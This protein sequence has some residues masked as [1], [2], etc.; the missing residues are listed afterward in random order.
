MPGTRLEA[1]LHAVSD[2]ARLEQL[3]AD[4][5]IRDGYTVDPTGTRGPD[6]GRD[7]LL[8]RNG[9]Q[10]ILHCS[11][12]EQ[13]EEKLHEDAESA[14]DR[15]ED[16]T[17]FIFATTQNPAGTRRDRLEAEISD[18]YGWHVTILD[19]ERLR[20]RLSGNPDNHDLVRDHLNIDPSHA[21]QDPAVDA[22]TFYND[23]IDRLQERDG[24][25][26]TIATERTLSDQDDLPILAVHIIPAE[27]FGGDHDRLGADLPDPPGFGQRGHTQRYGDFVLTGDSRALD[28]D[29]PFTHY[30]CFHE[31]GWAEAV[32]VNIVP[33]TDALE[34]LPNI[35]RYLVDFL[36][37]A[38]D[39]YQG[40]GINPPFHTYLSLLNAAA[41][42]TYVPDRVW[43]PDC[44]REIGSDVFRFGEVVIDRLDEDVPGLLRK[45]I[46]RLW[47]RTGWT[48]SLNY[49]E[50]EENGETFY[51]WNPR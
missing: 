18:E 30:S 50:V 24:Y 39:W 38:L 34:L 19:L 31:D 8:A 46:Y 33:K 48:T 6:G 37:D 35:D 15:P 14:V 13:W 27:A 40:V 4:L 36:E 47:S 5:L 12:S 25:Y 26:G 21:S 28:G 16:F 44:R 45:P 43:G 23:R 49:S 3:A 7:A 29:E 11:V 9:Q 2:G 17:F 10:G 41:Y 42:T 1:V 32:T 51:E 20:N 22:K